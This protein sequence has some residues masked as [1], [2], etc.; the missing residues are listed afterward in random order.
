MHRCPVRLIGVLI[1]SALLSGCLSGGFNYQPPP[2][3][4]VPPNSKAVAK[5]IDAVWKELVSGLAGRYFVINNIDRGSGLIN[6][7]YSGDPQLYVDCGELEILGRKC[8]R[9]AA[10]QI[11]GSII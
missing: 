11:S 6:L 2:D 3:S 9:Q 1:G 5:P 4:A 10:V 7:S 8:S